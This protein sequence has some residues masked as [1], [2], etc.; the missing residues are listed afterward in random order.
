MP[1]EFLICCFIVL[2]IV[3]TATIEF[4]FSLCYFLIKAYNC[5]CGSCI[6]QVK[7]WIFKI[8]SMK[9]YSAIPG[10]VFST[11]IV[12][13]C[14]Q[15]GFIASAYKP[16]SAKFY[17]QLIILDFLHFQKYNLVIVCYYFIIFRLTVI[18][19]LTQVNKKIL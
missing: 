9:Y 2:F 19:T 12:Y 16:K 8:F 18:I 11:V 14:K 5:A 15:F 7:D 17:R 3:D 1:V 10:N 6:V 4:K 13:L